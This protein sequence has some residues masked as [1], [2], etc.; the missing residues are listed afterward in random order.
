MD[1]ESQDKVANIIEEVFQDT[2]SLEVKE[3]IYNLVIVRK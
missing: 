2:I 1:K 3:L